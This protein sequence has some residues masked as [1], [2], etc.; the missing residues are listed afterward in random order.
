MNHPPQ[1][2]IPFRSPAEVTSSLSATIEHLNAHRVLAYPTETVYGLGGG[3]DDAAVTNLLALKER[4]PGKPFLML[5]DGVEMLARLGLTV[6]PTAAA[7]AA[8][9]WP[10]A[11][12][13][14]LPGGERRISD[15]L[16]G[17]EGGIAVRWTPHAGLTQL[18]G[19][20]GGPITSTSANHPGEPP[21]ESASAVAHAWSDAVESGALR[22][23][24]G[25]TLAPSLPSTVV[26]CM[27]AR[28]RLIRPG[29][30]S[31]ER[32]RMTAPT[33]VPAA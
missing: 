32:L 4:A 13:L 19:A 16:R 26:D 9:F 25:G 10:G 29:A 1:H 24:D 12:T 28:P 15:V 5:V 23:L 3:V 33:L 20:Y 31:A 17:P 21:A 22:V 30:I 11:L 18:I 2:V 27:G 7:L 14:V 6:T 8:A